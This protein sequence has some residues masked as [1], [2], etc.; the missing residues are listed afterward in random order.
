MNIISFDTLKA[1]IFSRQYFI[2]LPPVLKAL[3]STPHQ[4]SPTNTPHAK[5]PPK[6]SQLT[7]KQG[8]RNW[9]VPQSEYKKLI[10]D[11]VMG[12]HVQP[13]IWDRAS[14]KP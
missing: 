11:N 3:A 9:L 14:G 4:L 10:H 6:S 2:S 1:Q 5:P 12:G 7:N 13:P 8:S